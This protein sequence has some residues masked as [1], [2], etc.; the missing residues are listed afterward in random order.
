MAQSV[1]APHTCMTPV[2]HAA[3][4][5][6]VFAPAAPA[7]QTWPIAQSAVPM[8]GGVT[9]HVMNPYAPPLCI[10]HVEPMGQSLSVMH[11]GRAPGGQ[12]AMH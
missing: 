3:P 10:W 12:E 11:V 2:A 7:Q 1:D 6:H 4:V 9:W 5:W 8:H